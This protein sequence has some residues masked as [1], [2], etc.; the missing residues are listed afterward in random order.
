MANED[1]FWWNINA[2]F[3]DNLMSDIH[4]KLYED[5]LE[6]L[7]NLNKVKI[8]DIGC[9]TGE[10]IFRMPKTAIIRGI[11]YS[12]KAIKK[13]EEKCIDHNAKFLIMDFYSKLPKDYKPDKI[14]ACRS[15]YHKDLSLSLR[16]LSE[17]LNEGGLAV[18]V[19]PKPKSSE[20]M[21]LN[22]ASK[23]TKFI[24]FIKLFPRILSKMFG[25]SYNL[26]NIKDFERIGKQYFS[27][28]ESSE[29]GYGTHYLIKL[30]K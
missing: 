21:E 22:G 25:Y 23:I 24:Q 9:G 15:L 13:A 7:G 11:D 12:P 1:R 8:D 18:I 14:V 29:A 3:Y 5:A 28:V 19:H 16:I 10:L 30:R 26:F 27:S 2:L 17:H 4:T 6:S 20:Y